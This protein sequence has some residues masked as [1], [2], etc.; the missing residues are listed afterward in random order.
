VGSLDHRSGQERSRH[1]PAQG[2]TY[3]TTPSARRGRAT[4]RPMQHP[5]GD[6]IAAC[7]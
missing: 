5:Y 2:L 4:S 7:S 1:P 6:P 3:S